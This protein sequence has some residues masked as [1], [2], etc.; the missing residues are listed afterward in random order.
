M[1]KQD[2]ETS[3]SLPPSG[4]AINGSSIRA[5]TVVVVVVAVA[6][7]D[8]VESSGM[9]SYLLLVTRG[10]AMRDRQQT[11]GDT[12]YEDINYLVL[13]TVLCTSTRITD[14]KNGRDDRG[15]GGFFWKPSEWC[16][17]R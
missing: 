8:L 12:R 7:G 17:Y 2:S 1:D 3:Y 9:I 4:I 5:K 6:V 13:H 10:G 16:R 11:P 15:S 14:Q